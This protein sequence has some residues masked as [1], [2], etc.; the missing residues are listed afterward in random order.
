MHPFFTL[1]GNRLVALSSDAQ[2]AMQELA[3]SMPPDV[4]AA[5]GWK[6]YERFRPGE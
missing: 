2:A 3:S 4:L 5:E 1:L 6:L